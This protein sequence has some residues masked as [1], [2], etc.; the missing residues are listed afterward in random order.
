MKAISTAGRRPWSTASEP[1]FWNTGSFLS[2]L[3]QRSLSPLSRLSGSPFLL[4]KARAQYPARPSPP[5]PGKGTSRFPGAAARHWALNAPLSAKTQ[6]NPTPQRAHPNHG[7]RRGVISA[8]V[9]LQDPSI[10]RQYGQSRFRVQLS[11][12]IMISKIVRSVSTMPG[13]LTRPMPRMA[14]SG[15]APQMPSVDRSTTPSRER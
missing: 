13:A 1:I 15:V 2:S 14:S 10:S 3:N 9:G 6:K 4:P 12:S 8:A 7:T 5:R 11:L